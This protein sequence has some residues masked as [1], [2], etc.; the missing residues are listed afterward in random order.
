MGLDT[1]LVMRDPNSGN[2]LGYPMELFAP[3]WIMWQSKIVQPEL[4][5]F[6]SKTLGT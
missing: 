4:K 3:K 1:E 6:I 2:F 5:T